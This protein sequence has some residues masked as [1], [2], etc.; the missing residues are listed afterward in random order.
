MSYKDTN[1][2]Q[3]QNRCDRFHHFDAPCF[4]I[5]TSDS[6][7]W[8]QAGFVGSKMVSSLGRP[9]L[10]SARRSQPM[11]ATRRTNWGA[12]QV[13]ASLGNGDLIKRAHLVMTFW[14]PRV[15]VLSAMDT[16]LE[17]SPPPSGVLLGGLSSP[18][19]GPPLL[20]SRWRP[21][22][23][24]GF[25]GTFGARKSRPHQRPSQSRAGAIRRRR[26][27]SGTA[28]SL[29]R[30]NRILWRLDRGSTGQLLLLP[31]ARSRACAQRV[32]WG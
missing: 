24:P 23:W 4:T 31:R 9:G 18:P 10:F 11:N 17:T 13:R 12:A 25:S 7:S 22:R 19:L 28:L 6:R 30:E 3:T 15:A 1:A 8:F 32:A 29:M 27:P 21:M 2:K 16:R 20:D 5:V 26:R 14:R